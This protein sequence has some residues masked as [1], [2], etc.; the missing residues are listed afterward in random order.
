MC[1]TADAPDKRVQYPATVQAGKHSKLRFERARTIPR[2]IEGKRSDFVR[3]IPYGMAV[4]RFL[5]LGSGFA[6]SPLTPALSPL[7]G[8]G[9]LRAP[10]R[11][12]IP[13]NV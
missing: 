7:R 13:S 12:E 10:V 4:L 6:F 2:E 8:E 3:S 5:S 11:F 1:G 9:V